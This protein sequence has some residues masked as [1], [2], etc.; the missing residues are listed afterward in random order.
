MATAS[1]AKSKIKSKLPS[2][3]KIQIPQM[4]EPGRQPEDEQLG[5]EPEG[6][7]TVQQVLTPQTP[8]REQQP[9]MQASQGGI[10]DTAIQGE[11]PITGGRRAAGS[12]PR[13]VYVDHEGQLR[14][15]TPDEFA[16]FEKNPTG[17]MMGRILKH[18]PTNVF[19]SANGLLSSESDR[20]LYRLH[21]GVLN[22]TDVTAIPAKAAKVAG[23]KA[24][25]VARIGGP[26]IIYIDDFKQRLY[27]V[28]SEQFHNIQADPAKLINHKVLKH[29]PTCV[30][31]NA[32]G[33]FNSDEPDRRPMYGI[34]Y[35]DEAKTIISGLF[36]VNVEHVAEA[37]S[38]V[39]D[40]AP[41]GAMANADDLLVDDNQQDD[42]QNVQQ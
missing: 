5:D 7:E 35:Q 1:E 12:G 23:E 6:D 8:V 17:P 39:A 42:Q 33:N 18:L 21:E 40:E 27:S 34:Q 3:T 13:L 36:E 38:A 25:K 2:K 37:T 4:S 30:K 24:P 41:E 16:A 26:S 19:K 15:L 22:Q 29:L 20:P 9:K 31:K 14:S 32:T 11:A 10:T 28:N